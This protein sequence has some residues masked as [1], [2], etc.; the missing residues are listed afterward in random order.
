MIKIMWFDEPVTTF[1]PAAIELRLVLLASGAFVLFYA[2]IGGWL[3][4]LAE[5]AAKTFF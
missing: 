2:L 1:V 4:G 5:T 3:G